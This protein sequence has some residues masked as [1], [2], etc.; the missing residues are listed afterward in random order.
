ML[1]NTGR[2]L[3]LALGGA[4][5]GPLS[6]QC[7]GSGVVAIHRT[8]ALWLLGQGARPTAE[9]ARTDGSH[10]QEM[11]ERERSRE[12]GVTRKDGEL[13][14]TATA[15]TFPHALNIPGCLVP[16]TSVQPVSSLWVLNRVEKGWLH[17]ASQLPDHG[18][19][20]PASLVTSLSQAALEFPAVDLVCGSSSC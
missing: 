6:L 10:V 12:S 7:C 8:I 14:L 13:P 20:D 19:G 4:F 15:S 16:G 9:G 17:A 3:A 11:R 1:G 18:V 2:I 5:S